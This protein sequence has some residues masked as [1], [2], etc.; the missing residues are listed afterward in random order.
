MSLINKML[1]D[2]EKR[3]AFLND[4][5]DPILDGLYSAYDL[6]LTGKR[7]S[8]IPFIVSIGIISTILIFAYLFYSSESDRFQ[9]VTDFNVGS[10]ST[11]ISDQVVINENNTVIKNSVSEP[12]LISDV[13]K[14]D[15]DVIKEVNTDDISTDAESGLTADTSK[16][17]QDV[18]EEINTVSNSNDTESELNIDTIEIENEKNNFLKL[19]NNL[20]LQGSLKTSKNNP[21][22][23]IDSIQFEVN[24]SGINLIM[25]MPYEIDYLVYG[26][27]NPNRTVIEVENAEL[28]FRIEDMI[29]VEPIV[30]IRY[31]INEQ[32]RFK[33]VLES[34][35][36]LTIR[37][38]MTSKSAN[39]HDLVVVMEYQWEGSEL[40]QQDDIEL[41][42]IVEKQVEQERSTVFKGELIKT[43][44]NQNSDA[45]AEKLFQQGY[46]AYKKGNIS[47]SLKKLN[48]SLDQDAGHVKARSTLALVL[49]KQGHNELAY[50]V[51]N[52]GLIQYPGNTEWIKMYARFLLNEGKIVE[53]RSL[54][55]KQSPEISSNTE[56][57]ALQAAILQKLN[58]HAQTAKI[59]RDLLHVNPLNSVWWMGLGISLESMKRYNDALYAYQKAS[60]NPS[61]AKESREF[62]SHRINRLNNL[63]EDESA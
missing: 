58:E 46:I 31:S 17:D 19:D 52:E 14:S 50:S 34:D 4:N 53:A 32:K 11:R 15:Q 25:N 16:P 20:L 27:S 51:L 8:N 56:Y 61:L 57:Y 37:K 38:S 35:K 36:P 22:N 42:E 2:L 29:S 45:Y 39:A 10:S 44:V 62:L 21:L 23:R 5:Q 41:T 59:Y 26:L 6:E 24:S 33:L 28:G 12:D 9:T 48:K 47:E 55:D 1:N 40:L 49:S 60:N 7:K 54:L 43:P 13:S 3:D 18:I 63:L 30:A